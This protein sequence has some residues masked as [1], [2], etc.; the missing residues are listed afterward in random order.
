MQLYSTGL[1]YDAAIAAVAHEP[2]VAWDQIDPD[3]ATMI[4]QAFGNLHIV[5]SLARALGEDAAET[6][7][8][9]VEQIRRLNRFGKPTV[10]HRIDLNDGDGLQK[11]FVQ[12]NIVDGVARKVSQGRAISIDLFREQVRIIQVRRNGQI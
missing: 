3:D 10:W 9:F 6:Q 4:A 8:I 5:V 2:E 1:P 12:S 7:D 11:L